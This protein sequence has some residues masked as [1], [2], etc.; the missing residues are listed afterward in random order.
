ML[1]SKLTWWILGILFLIVAF[2][3]GYRSG[4]NGGLGVGY[5]QAVNESKIFSLFGPRRAAAPT[6]GGIDLAAVAARSATQKAA[7]EAAKAASPF[8]ASNP[9]N[10]VEI[11]SEDVDN[12]YR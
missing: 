9:I 8:L 10:E 7:E 2:L 12:P 11:G 4:L 6:G 1:T 3:L 5:N